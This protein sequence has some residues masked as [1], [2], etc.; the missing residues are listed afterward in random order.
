MRYNKLFPEFF[1]VNYAKKRGFLPFETA[2]LHFV[3][4]YGLVSTYTSP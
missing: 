2:S 1:L 4:V 3:E